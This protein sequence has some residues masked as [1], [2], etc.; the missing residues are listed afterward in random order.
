[1]V[2]LACHPHGRTVQAFFG[3]DGDAGHHQGGLLRRH[4]RLALQAFSRFKHQHHADDHDEQA[5]GERGQGFEPAVA[6]RMV[7]VGFGCSEA[8]GHVDHGIGDEVRQ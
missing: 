5:N 1:M 2:V 6:V 8:D 7:L 3:E 4:P